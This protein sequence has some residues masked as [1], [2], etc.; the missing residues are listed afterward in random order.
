M[1]LD[2]INPC[3]MKELRSVSESSD[4]LL[5]LLYG[6]RMGFREEHARHHRFLHRQHH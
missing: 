2:A 3:L 5:G 6:C 4:Y 1:Q